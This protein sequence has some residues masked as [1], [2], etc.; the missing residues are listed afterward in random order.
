MLG[1]PGFASSSNGAATRKESNLTQPR[2]GAWNVF[3][4]GLFHTS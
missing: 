2:L 4:S 3:R 1:L